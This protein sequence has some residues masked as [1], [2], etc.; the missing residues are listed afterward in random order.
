MKV[1]IDGVSYF[2]EP[3][4]HAEAMKLLRQVYGALWTEA[5]YDGNSE[6]TAKFAKPLADKMREA[7]K[8]LGFKQ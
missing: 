6:Q 4:P 8:I 1:T 3:E 7:N 2:P 5:Y